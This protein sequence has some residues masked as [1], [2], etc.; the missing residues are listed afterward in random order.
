MLCYATMSFLMLGVTVVN[1]LK[2]CVETG[3]IVGAVQVLSRGHYRVSGKRAWFKKCWFRVT[4][5]IDKA[6]PSK[7]F[8]VSFVTLF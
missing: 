5:K 8:R 7:G 4:P 1:A 6:A 3:S 2:A